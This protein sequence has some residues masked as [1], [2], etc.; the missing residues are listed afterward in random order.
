MSLFDA[1]NTAVAGLSAQEGAMGNISDN[2]AN[3]QTIGYKAIGTEFDS[4]VEYNGNFQEPGSVSIHSVY[5]TDVAGTLTSS[6]ESTSLAVNGNGFFVVKGPP[7]SQSTTGDTFNGIDYYTRRGDFNVNNAGYLV[8]GAGYFL[9]GYPINAATGQTASS[10]LS[11]I[12]IPEGQSAPQAT[13]LLTLAANLPD[14][15]VNTTTGAYDT[16]APVTTTIYDAQ[17]NAQTVTVQF[18]QVAPTKNTSDS[19]TVYTATITGGTGTQPVAVYTLDFS[20]GSGA[21]TSTGTNQQPAGSLEAVY[22]G[23]PGQPSST[24][25]LVGGYNSLGVAIGTGTNTSAALNPVFSFGSVKQPIS[26]NFGNIG[27]TSGLYSYGDTGAV[28]VTTNTA[29]GHAQG[30][31]SGVS[32]D[33]NGFVNLSFSNGQTEKFAQI[34]LAQFPATNQL[35]SLDGSTFE[36]TYASGAATVSLPGQNGSGQIAPGQLEQSNVSLSTQLT[37]LI[38]AQQVYTSNARVISTADQMLQTLTQTIQG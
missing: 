4:L 10:T 7:T 32:I 25:A 9:E 24:K 26:L 35:E 29:D 17:G 27:T 18:Q 30:E 22:K 1:L 19:A 36:A 5:H 38:T 15:A 3:A 34:A 11:P 21:A 28:D 23:L 33:E 8:N 20:N 13:S 31:L 14:D 16:P 12:Q 2:I 37:S 6:Q